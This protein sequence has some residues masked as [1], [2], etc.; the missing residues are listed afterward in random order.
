M[1]LPSLPEFELHKNEHGWGPTQLPAHLATMPFFPYSKNERIGRHID[2]LAFRRVTQ[3]N[4]EAAED[5]AFKLVDSA[6]QKKKVAFHKRG[7]RQFVQQGKPVKS[8]YTARQ[9]RARQMPLSYN[10]R[11]DKLNQAKYKANRRERKAYVNREATVNVKGSWNCIEQAELVDMRKYKATEVP[12]ASTLLECGRIHKYNETLAKITPNKVVPLVDDKF[13]RFQVLTLGDPYFEKL[14]GEEDGSMGNVF[15]PDS[16]LSHIMTAPRSV[17]PWD[18]EIIY[19]DGK[20]VFDGTPDQFCMY[21]TQETGG[22]SVPESR[23]HPNHPTNLTTEATLINH[24]FSSQSLSDK[25]VEEKPYPNPFLEDCE[26]DQEPAPILYRYRRF[27]LGQNDIVV[28]TECHATCKAMG[29]NKQIYCTLHALNEVEARNKA[30]AWSKRLATKPGSV[31]ADEIKNNNHKVSKWVSMSM[32][33]GAE[34]MKIAF[35]SRKVMRD[36]QNHVI[37]GVHTARPHQLATQVGLTQSNM[38]GIIEH[39]L[40]LVR[41]NGEGKYVL[42]RDPNKPL[43]RLYKT[44]DD[45]SDSDEEESSEEETE[46]EEES[47]EEESEEESSDEE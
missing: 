15:V 12:E 10:K 9:M 5:G 24:C 17:N 20:I 6:K 11:Y 34:E 29:K 27:K 7:A 19:V 31:V 26:E 21:T 44:D 41:A 36:N 25:I 18:C 46:S 47:S 22:M 14:A 28:R 43:M 2:F 8:Q 23:D 39:I 35:V 1:E 16:I 3:R 38:W 4:V 33:S 45:E 42:M 37:M 13:T 40:K 32:L 30:N